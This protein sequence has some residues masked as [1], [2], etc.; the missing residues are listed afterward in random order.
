M[1]KLFLLGLALL[2][3][4]VLSAQG[5]TGPAVR[6]VMQVTTVQVAQ[7]MAHKSRITLVGNVVQQ[8]DRQHYIFRDSS[9][10]MTVKISD[11]YWGRLTVGSNDLVE[12]SGEV[13]RK[14]DGRLEIKVHVIRRA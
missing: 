4:G 9:G 6:T 3:S 14:R 1:K 5:F 8:I 12:I 11:K 7:G 10:E 2:L 13:D